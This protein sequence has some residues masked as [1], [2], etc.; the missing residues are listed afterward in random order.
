MNQKTSE[1]AKAKNRINAAIVAGTISGTLTLILSLANIGGLNSFNLIDVAIAYGLSYGIYRKSRVCAV[2][3]FAYFVLSKLEQISTGN[4]TGWPIALIFAY[5][6]FLGIWGTFTFH[7]LQTA[8]ASSLKQPYEPEPAESF[9]ERFILHL[10]TGKD[11]E[12]QPGTRLTMSNIPG[13]ETLTSDDPTVAEVSRNPQQPLMLGLKNHSTQIWRVTTATGKLVPINP[14]ENV[15]LHVGTRINFIGFL[16][17]EISA[18]FR[19]QS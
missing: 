7:K 13:L 19:Y 18:P 4:F 2:L 15:R 16:V 8:S 6:F 14:G 9:P 5:C 10:S 11:L 3:L 12:L 1:L 17:G